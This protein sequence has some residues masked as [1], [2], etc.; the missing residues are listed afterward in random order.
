MTPADDPVALAER[1]LTILEE[2]S[3]SATYKY[4]LLVAILDLCLERTD[5]AGLPPESL[6][7]RQLADKVVEIYWD[8]ALPFHIHGPLRQGGGQAGTQAEIIRRIAD[9]RAKWTGA[10]ADTVHRCRLRHPKRTS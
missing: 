9:F 5:D 8:H 7:T 1:V 10:D 6:T 2:G 3:F 4:A